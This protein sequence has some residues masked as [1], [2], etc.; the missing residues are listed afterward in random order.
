MRRDARRCLRF[1]LTLDF[2]RREMY[3]TSSFVRSWCS[4]A[5]EQFIRPPRTSQRTARDST[6]IVVGKHGDVSRA[7]GVSVQ[8]WDDE[9]GRVILWEKR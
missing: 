5:C 3:S 7:Y 2:R 9:E 8:T 1:W 6:R 4:H